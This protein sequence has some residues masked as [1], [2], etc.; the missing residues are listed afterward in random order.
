MDVP[1]KWEEDGKID[2]AV[3]QQMAADGLLVALAW[4]ARIPAEWAKKDGTVF[5]GV[6]ASEWNGFVSCRSLWRGRN[7][8]EGRRPAPSLI[9]DM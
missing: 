6:K 7:V 5:G 9:A 3:Y 8:W 4:G 1:N 2:P